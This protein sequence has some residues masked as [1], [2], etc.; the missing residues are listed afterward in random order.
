VQ[1]YLVQDTEIVSA[2]TNVIHILILVQV[3]NI[4]CEAIFS[5]PGGFAASIS[6]EN[7]N[8]NLTSAMEIILGR[9]WPAFM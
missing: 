4:I 2:I 1:H 6:L 7:T 5:K 8:F 3:S 9:G